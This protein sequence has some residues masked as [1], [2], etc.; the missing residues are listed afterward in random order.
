MSKTFQIS[1]GLHNF[2]FVVDF[3]KYYFIIYRSKAFWW[4]LLQWHS[5]NGSISGFLS[6]T[7]T[8][9]RKSRRSWC[10][11]RRRG[12]WT[13]ASTRSNSTSRTLSI[14]LADSS[15]RRQKL[16][17]TPKRKRN[18]SRFSTQRF[19][20]KVN[21]L[22]SQ[23]RLAYFITGSIT[24]LLASWFGFDQTCKSLSNST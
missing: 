22:S 4:R 5:C 3:K 15:T 13:A 9:T 6:K 16:I 7:S 11:T 14:G 20:L 23:W 2:S 1:N 17:T 8:C 10:A 12:T 19:E 24:V 18:R 21:S